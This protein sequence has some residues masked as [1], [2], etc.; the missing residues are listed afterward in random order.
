MQPDRLTYL[1]TFFSSP[2]INVGHHPEDSGHQQGAL[3]FMFWPPAQQQPVQRPSALAS[4]GYG[5]VPHQGEI[6][7]GTT[8]RGVEVGGRQGRASDCVIRFILISSVG[9]TQC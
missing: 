5:C 7:A 9:A 8:Q 1:L 3:D 4:P 6:R 2:S